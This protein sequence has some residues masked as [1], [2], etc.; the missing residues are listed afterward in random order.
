MIHRSRW[1]ACYRLVILSLLVVSSAWRL[2]AQAGR[3]MA[4][5]EV[6]KLAATLDSIV[7]AHR[8]L[9][10]IPGLSIAIRRIAGTEVYAKGYGFADLASRQPVTSQTRFPIYSVSKVYASALTHQLIEA[11]N[12]VLDAPVGRYLPELPPWRD[13]L[14]IRHLLAHASGLVDYTDLPGYHE[15]VNAGTIG[16]SHFVALALHQPLQFMPG[17]KW[18]YSNT[19]YALVERLVER[20]S[21]MTFAQRLR[22]GILAP[23]RFRATSIDCDAAGIATGYTWAWRAGLKGDSLVVSKGRNARLNLAAV[24]GLC[25][26]A[27]EVAR[28][29]AQLLQAQ[30]VQSRSLADMSRRIPEGIAKSG[31]GLFVQEDDEGV[32]LEHGG[33]G[34]N[35]NAHVMAFVRDSLVLTA[36]ANSGGAELDELLRIIR[37]RILGIP[38]PSVEETAIS[39]AE[40]K[41]LQGLYLDQSSQR[42]QVYERDG[43]LSAFGG[44]LFRQADGSYVPEMVRNLR[45]TFQSEDGVVTGVTVSKYGAVIMVARRAP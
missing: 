5:A 25:S 22:A 13:S 1:N 26:T 24:G 36:I 31:A 10:T 37:R 45:L 33:G 30:H 3:R 8:K 6:S 43:M 18:A 16:E 9:Q 2:P 28:F 40:A 12:L 15:A 41:E 17:S 39:G 27:P 38:E 21:G 4:A 32:I 14:T 29:V 34:G 7:E 42:V 35:G 23:G 19:G 11:G 20:V 44:R